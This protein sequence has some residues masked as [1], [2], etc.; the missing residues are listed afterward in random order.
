M[1]LGTPNAAITLSLLASDGRT[2]LYAQCTIYDDA[3]STVSTETLTH[4][5]QG[6]YT[7]QHTPTT[8][9][10]FSLVYDF[11]FDPA[12]TISAGYQK[13]GETLDVNDSRTNILRLLGLVHENSVVDEHV[14]DSEGKLLNARIRTYDNAGNAAAAAAISPAPYPTGLTFQYGMSAVYVSGLLD[15]YYI[16]RQM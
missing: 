12:F 4:V 9:G 16:T 5:D 7:V 2:D 8:A 6:L 11:F 13:Q 3:G 10:Y 14:Y 15:R 1:L